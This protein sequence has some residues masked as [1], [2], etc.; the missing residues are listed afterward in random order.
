M[1]YAISVF[2][3]L[4][5][6]YAS[7]VTAYFTGNAQFIQTASYRMGWQCEYQ[8]GANYFYVTFVTH[9]CPLTVEIQ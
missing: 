3:L 2:L 6:S 8:Y 1:R 5:S 7:A 4:F 9:Y